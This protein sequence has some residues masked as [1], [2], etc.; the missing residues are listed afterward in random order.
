MAEPAGGFRFLFVQCQRGAEAACKAEV[1]EQ[2]PH[3]RFAFSRRG[4]LTFRV[5]AEG[6]D[7]RFDLRSTFARTYGWSIARV[8]GSDLKELA[9]KVV[10]AVGALQ[11]AHLH[12]WQ[13]DARLTD[14][15]DGQ[16][17]PIDA[18]RELGQL[19]IDTWPSAERPPLNRAARAGQLVLDVVLV[20]GSQAVVGFHHADQVVRRWPGGVPRPFTT[21]RPIS[22]AYAKLGE[23][24]AWSGIRI[25]AGDLCAEIGA[26]PGGACQ[27]LLELGARV[28]AVDPAELDPRI[29]THPQLVHL[30]RRG[31]DVR[32]RDLARVQWLLCD[33]NIT[34]RAA[35]N[36]LEPLVTDRRVRLSGILVTLKL[37][38]YSMASE[39]AEHVARARS[40]GFPHVKTRQLA[41]GRREVCLVAMQKRNTQRRKS[42]RQ[43]PRRRS[44]QDK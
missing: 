16:P 33:A 35:M 13:P 11:P 34:P 15:R 29:A 22:R 30:R 17:A 37:R 19:M 23:A 39:I 3:S 7:E 27:L 9:G 14:P 18:A 40:W 5:P 12:V 20:D 26:A 10:A 1:A 42:A 44:S 8:Q 21:D 6:V 41:F 2:L 25:G 28:I 32:R 4:L 43:R 36:M 24:L 31:R 38:D